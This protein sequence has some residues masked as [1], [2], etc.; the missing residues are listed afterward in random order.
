MQEEYRE[1]GYI[2]KTP[3][4][5][6]PVYPPIGEEVPWLQRYGPW[7]LGGIAFISAMVALSK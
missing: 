3:I 5:Y 2:E 7:I 4:E 1:A 6:P